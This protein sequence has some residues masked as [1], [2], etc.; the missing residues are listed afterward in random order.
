MSATRRSPITSAAS[1]LARSNMRSW[2]RMAARIRGG[3]DHGGRPVRLRRRHCP[4]ESELMRGRRRHRLWFRFGGRGG[5]VGS[6]R[7]VGAGLGFETG[8][9][10]SGDASEP[11]PLGGSL[12]IGRNYVELLTLTD[13][14]VDCPRH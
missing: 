8:T 12:G 6:G 11:V 4:W 10:T 3:D 5:R 14:G 2:A 9:W 13:M 7:A 1:Y